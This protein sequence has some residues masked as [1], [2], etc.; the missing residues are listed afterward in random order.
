MYSIL[1]YYT[2]SLYPNSANALGQFKEIMPRSSGVD[3]VD[4]EIGRKLKYSK[5]VTF[6]DLGR[7][8]DLVATHN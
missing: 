1:S 7:N 2:I 5:G 6:E 8:K 4:S 3:R